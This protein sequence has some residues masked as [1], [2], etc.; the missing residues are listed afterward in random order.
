MNV[1]Y[2]YMHMYMHMH[3][4]MLHVH[5]VYCILVGNFL[6]SFSV[7]LNLYELKFPKLVYLKMKLW[8]SGIRQ[9]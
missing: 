4:C 1:M 6:A 5:V 2:M 7:L 3:M 8:P 9:I